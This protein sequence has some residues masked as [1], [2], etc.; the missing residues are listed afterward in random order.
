MVQDYE[1]QARGNMVRG[2]YTNGW[3]MLAHNRKMDVIANNLANV[4]THGYKKET[5][6][7]ASFPELM[8]KRIYD[9][10]SILNPT[11]E[12]GN[13]ELS[14]DISQNFVYYNPGASEWTEKSLDFAIDDYEG[15]ENASRAR[16]F[17][18][19]EYQEP[20]GPGLAER[21]T[22]DGAFVIGSDQVLRTQGGNAVLGEN[23]YIRLGDED[24]T[25]TNDGTIIQN[26]EIID[27]LR[28]TSFED[29]HTLR[30]MGAGLLERTD[31][32]VERPFD[33]VLRQGYL[34]QSN[35]NTVSEMVDMIT[36]MRAYEANQ[37][38]VHFIDGTLE[39]V[40]NEVGR[41]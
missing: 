33:G 39:K 31:Q 28:I 30:K 4:N 21:Y 27:R 1:R 24:F 12:V 22:R 25:L 37:K 18:T 17:F 6:C 15:E 23:G 38:M 8:V 26:N 14:A 3:S 40:C 11:G 34:E 9:T 5:A 29:P 20:N 35:V 7:F 36:V 16:S 32:S 2:L 10:P 19:I 41:V 13:V